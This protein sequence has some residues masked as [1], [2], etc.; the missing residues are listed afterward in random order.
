MITLQ[1]LTRCFGEHCVIKGLDF[2]F[3]ERGVV[4]LMGESGCGKTTVLRLLCRLDRPDGGEIMGLPKRIAVCF[5]EPRLIN[6]LNCIDNI[7]FVLPKENNCLDFASNLFDQLG[8]SDVKESLPGALSGGMKQRLSLIRALSFRGDLLLLDEPF[9]GLDEVNTSKVAKLI[10]DAAKQA[11]VIVVTHH[12]EEA[13]LLGKDIYRLE[14]SPVRA[15]T[16]LF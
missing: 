13:K 16:P 2:R 15:L 8:L 7:K 10:R 9:N 4:T 3:P 6:H 1:N 12:I 5:Q 11:P 14:G